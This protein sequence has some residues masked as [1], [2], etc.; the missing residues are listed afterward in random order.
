MSRIRGSDTRPELQF[1][2]GLF[3]LGYRYR[4]HRRDL[5]GKPDL[6][7]PKY[8]AAVLI[9][10]CFWHGHDCHLFRLPKTRRD[11]W[12]AKIES[13]RARDQRVREDLIASHWRVLTVWECSMRGHSRQDFKELLSSV[14]FW[15]LSEAPCLDVR[16]GRPSRDLLVVIENGIPKA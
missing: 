6:V 13:N 9:H 11:F 2:K 16:G 4:L 3:A 14:E 15:L 12:R 1:R 7:L 10:G 8:R 5:P